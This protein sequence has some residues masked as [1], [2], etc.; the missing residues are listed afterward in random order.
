MGGHWALGD[1]GNM[2]NAYTGLGSIS[3]EVSSALI[4]LARQNHEADFRWL[5]ASAGM[6]PEDID[7]LWVVLEW[8][9]HGG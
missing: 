9:T 8:H 5:A 1:T 4:D 6:P 7:V 3:H 2:P